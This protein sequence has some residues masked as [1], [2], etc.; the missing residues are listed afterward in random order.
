MLCAQ[1]YI[2]ESHQRL[3]GFQESFG[4]KGNQSVV[5]QDSGALLLD[6]MRGGHI[7]H[8]DVYHQEPSQILNSYINWLYHL[9][10]TVVHKST[11]SWI[12]IH[13]IHI[14][15]S[16]YKPNLIPY[17]KLCSASNIKTKDKETYDV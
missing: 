8:Y 15:G 12:F 13:Y 4:S 10:K 2:H 7:F 9:A 6:E 16:F 11:I 17:N 5:P 1:N 3:I 14:N